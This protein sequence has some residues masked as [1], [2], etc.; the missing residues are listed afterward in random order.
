MKPVHL[1]AL[2]AKGPVTQ[3]KGRRGQLQMAKA[4]LRGIK[5]AHPPEYYRQIP[6]WVLPEDIF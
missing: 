5:E 4:T 3:F 1:A 2:E 6:S